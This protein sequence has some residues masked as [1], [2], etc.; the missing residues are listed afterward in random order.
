MQIGQRLLGFRDRVLIALGLAQF[1]QFQRVVE[2]PLESAIALDG[3]FEAAALT[4]QRL[5]AG[6]IVPEVGVFD[7]GVQFIQTAKGLFPVKDASS[8]EPSPGGF[9]L[10]ETASRRA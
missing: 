7:D 6:L 2:I 3:G 10:Q 8:G 5:G 4:G 1:D 9:R